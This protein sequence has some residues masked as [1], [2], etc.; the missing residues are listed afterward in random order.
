[1]DYLPNVDAACY[2]TEEILPLIRSAHPE[3]RFAIVG[4]NPSKRVRRLAARPGTVV[5]GAVP[6]VQPYLEHAI[7]A[8]A[9]FR[10]CQGVQNKILEAL[11]IGL[12][13]VATPRPARAVGAGEKELLFVA[14]GAEEFAQAV[15]R[16]LENPE[17]R[18]GSGGKEFV[19]R[20][21]NWETNLKPLDRWI[22]EIAS[23]GG[24]VSDEAKD[25]VVAN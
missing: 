14:E 1:M 18:R 19:E 23:T 22:S 3:L 5:I 8:V 24:G 13:V 9:P 21:Y 25:Y 16:L 10:I 20:Q 4:R 12:P 11:S 6:E 17:M 2:F 15:R 7:A